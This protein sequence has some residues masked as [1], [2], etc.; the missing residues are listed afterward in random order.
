MSHVWTTFAIGH[1]FRFSIWNF[2]V[3]V[4]EEKSQD[5]HLFPV[6]QRYW[7]QITKVSL[8]KLS[9]STV[10]HLPGSLYWKSSWSSWA[11]IS[12]RLWSKI[13]TQ[14]WSSRWFCHSHRTGRRS[15]KISS[16]HRN[17]FIFLRHFIFSLSIHH[18][19]RNDLDGTLDDPTSSVQ[20]AVE[21]IRIFSRRVLT[22]A[23][24][25]IR[26]QWHI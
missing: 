15:S 1:P 19:R 20:I 2:D 22:N 3:F 4:V 25:S 14:R 12:H 9:R 6:R 21:D 23:Y 11:S 7:C 17:G 16:W 26:S 13:K 18:V 5:C 10:T 8:S 24:E